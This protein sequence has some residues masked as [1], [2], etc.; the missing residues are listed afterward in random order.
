MEQAQDGGHLSLWHF[1][2][3]DVCLHLLFPL[4]P[5]LFSFRI[6]LFSRSMIVNAP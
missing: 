6:D 1:G 5:H 4:C 2:A 3:C